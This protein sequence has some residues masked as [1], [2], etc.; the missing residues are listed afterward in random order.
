MIDKRAQSDKSGLQKRRF[1]RIYGYKRRGRQMEQNKSTM[2]VAAA[3]A[4]IAIAMLLVVKVI[5]PVCTGMVE[6]AAGKQIPMRCHYTDAAVTLFAFLLLVC[7]VACFVT[8]Q[9]VACG[10]MAVAIGV[11]GFVVLSST[12]GIGICANPEMACNVTAPYIKLCSTLALLTGAA[13]V[14]LGMKE[15]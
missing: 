7:A 11:C 9:K 1:K 15:K 13:S 10:M 5:A 2:I 8:K 4:V 3:Q 14:F 6:T 12:L